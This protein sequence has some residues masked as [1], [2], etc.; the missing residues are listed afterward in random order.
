MSRVGIDRKSQITL[1]VGST[2]VPVLFVSDATHLTN[3]SSD[4]KVWP[5]YMSIGNIRS[6]I[7]NKPTSHA[8]VLVVILPNAPKHIKK[9]LGWSEE[10]QV[11][12][13]MQVLHNSLKFVPR[14][15][16][17]SA[18]DGHNIK[19]GDEVVRR[20]YFRVAGWLADHMENSVIHGIYTTRCTIC[21]SPQDRLG[22]LHKYPLRDAQQ[23]REWIDKSDIESLHIR[24]VK[25]ITN[26]LWTLRDMIPRELV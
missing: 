26:A 2:L 19:Y 15:L 22:D 16:S 25:C 7:Y 14:P 18:L 13:A 9:V 3:F 8:W 5:L 17:N 10:K 24:G 4:S 12:E 6:G 21:K 23:Y 1:S 20:C 11:Y